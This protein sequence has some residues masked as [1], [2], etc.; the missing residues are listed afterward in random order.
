MTAFLH[1]RGLTARAGAFT[2]GEVSIELE[3][4]TYFVLMGPSACGK[5]TLLKTLAGFLP[6]DSGAIRID[7]EDVTA[8]P[9]QKRGV[10]YVSQTALLFPHLSVRDNIA[11]GLRYTRL[12]PAERE[13]AVSAMTALVGAESLLDRAPLTLSGGE[14]R[15]VALARALAVRPRVLLL[16]EPLS[17]LDAPARLGLLDM[18]NKIH[19]DHNGVTL[20]VTHQ[21]EDAVLLD[22]FCGIMRDGRLVQT[23]PI[24]DLLNKPADRFVDDF[25]KPCRLT[26]E[27][28]RAVVAGGPAGGQSG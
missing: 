13:A 11:F 18:L 16:D 25:L 5:T 15:R 27:R 22:A 4:G 26:S 6:C 24:R 20:H 28:I 1:I 8:L 2:L 9:P 10:G 7:G 3:R 17:M 12:A 14:S 19:A 23:G 21:P